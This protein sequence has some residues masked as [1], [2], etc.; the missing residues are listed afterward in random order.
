VT[1]LMNK[2]TWQD[3]PCSI[4]LGQCDACDW[5]EKREAELRVAE[6]G[7]VLG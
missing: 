5:T 3:F 1:L 4:I 2:E 7:S 6:T